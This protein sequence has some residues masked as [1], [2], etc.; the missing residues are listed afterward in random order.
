[1]LRQ[2]GWLGI[3]LFICFVSCKK[4]DV[5]EKQV[6]IPN[7][8][9]SKTFVPTFQFDNA[10]S[11]NQNFVFAVIRHTNNYPYN[12][13]WVRLTATSPKDSIIVKDINIPLTTNNQN[14]EWAGV[15]MDD[16]FEVR[17]KLS[18]FS[19]E[20]GNYTFKLENIMRDNPLPEIMNVGLRIEK[21]K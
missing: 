16:V 20:V 15:G 10:I 21:I 11:N 2:S 19:G 12:N 17:A 5:Y 6:T 1:M 3:L 14:K 18:P 7:F 13:I 9:W 8:E 4:I